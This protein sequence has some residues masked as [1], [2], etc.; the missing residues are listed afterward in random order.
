MKAYDDPISSAITERS[1]VI[2]E[3]PEAFKTDAVG[4]P[5]ETLNLSLYGK[6]MAA[7]EARRRQAE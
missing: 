3:P 4:S 7:R 5:S 6:V 1:G 2:W